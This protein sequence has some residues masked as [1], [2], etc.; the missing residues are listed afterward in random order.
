MDTSTQEEGLKKRCIPCRAA[1]ALAIVV[2][3]STTG[4]VIAI[5]LD[6]L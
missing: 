5:Y 1:L 6:Y 4:F 2:F 3:L